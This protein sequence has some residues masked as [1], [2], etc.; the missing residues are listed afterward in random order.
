MDWP[1]PP[2]GFPLE[3]WGERQ[4]PE[5]VTQERGFADDI[6]V[7]HSVIDGNPDVDAIYRLTRRRALDAFRFAPDDEALAVS[8]N[9]RVAGNTQATFF[10]KPAVFAAMYFPVTV[11]GRVADVLRFYVLQKVLSVT[12]YWLALCSPL[13]WQ[14]RNEHDLRAISG[15]RSRCTCTPHG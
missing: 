8:R 5:Q 2:R 7:L 10:L 9:V 14:E 6:A 15:A 12:P 4:A 3:L 1:R 11:D 13:C